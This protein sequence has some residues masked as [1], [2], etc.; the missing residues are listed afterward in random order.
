MS[1]DR[2]LLVLRNSGLFVYFLYCFFPRPFFNNTLGKN[3]SNLE[4]EQSF[5]EQK[6]KK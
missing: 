1:N 2:S 3:E 5:I 4:K 6:R